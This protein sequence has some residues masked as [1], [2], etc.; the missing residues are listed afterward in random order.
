MRWRA[1]AVPPRCMWRG[2][3]TGAERGKLGAEIEPVLELRHRFGIRVVE[4][5]T[6]AHTAR[7]RSGAVKGRQVSN[8]RGFVCFSFNG[9]K[10]ITS[11]SGGMLVSNDAAS[12]PRAR[13][14][15]N[16]AKSADDGYMRDEIRYN[17]RMS[18]LAAAVGVAQV[19]QLD[20]FLA[21]AAPSRWLYSVMPGDEAASVVDLVRGLNARG[22]QG[23]RLWSPLLRRRTYVSCERLG[24]AVADDIYQRVL[25]LAQLGGRHRRGTRPGGDRTLQPVGA[26]QPTLQ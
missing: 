21:R 18:H 7:W 16:Q 25:S 5:A 23:R 3:L 12:A 2:R 15:V 20:S 17:Y 19:E 26:A 11:G 8:I 13:H 24:G 6:G 1:R 14:L 9:N 22:I 4:D 10:L